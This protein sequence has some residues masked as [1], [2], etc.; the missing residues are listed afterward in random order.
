MKNVILVLIII[1]FLLCILLLTLNFWDPG[2]IE[3]VDQ[4]FASFI[5][6]KNDQDTESLTQTTSQSP[7]VSIQTST[8]RPTKREAAITPM[9][10]QSVNQVLA[11]P[12]KGNPFDEAQLSEYMLTLINN[13]RRQEN[14]S[15]VVWDDFAASV[16]KSHAEEMVSNNYMAHWNLDGYGPDIRYALAGGTAW[17][18]ENV[19]S[20][21]W[22]YD[23][24]S[25]VPIE[26]W[27][28]EID[29]A[30]ENLMNSPGH[31]ANIIN[32]DHTHVGVGFAY[33]DT[34]G[35]FRIA[36]EFINKYIEMESIP[37]IVNP[38]QT[39]NIKGR[40]LQN[41]YDPILN[42]AYESNPAKMSIDQLN[43]TSTYNSPAQFTE[44][45]L[46]DV[47]G[48]QFS[49]NIMVGSKEGL[50]HIRIWVTCS[51]RDFQAVDVILINQN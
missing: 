15:P 41:V 21:Y 6:D 5:T 13:S 19:Y 9:V 1:Y 12:G 43:K 39:I 18:Q 44:A 51:E 14:L 46:L 47:D 42:I 37:I 7:V 24:G 10:I 45:V 38:G 25:A 33:D 17:V 11:T 4:M 32:P 22:R 50:Y 20:S 28:A 31:R 35:E 49:G 40:L 30:H 34:N 48:D 26:N 23:D 36:Q 29:K 2:E 3:F 27:E 8:I 16:G